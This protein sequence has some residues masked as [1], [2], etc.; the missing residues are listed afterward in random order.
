MADK[1]LV[2]DDSLTV[3]MDLADALEGAG[4]SV[5]H[6]ASAEEARKAVERE[7]VSVIV[8][9]VV[10]PDAD[11]IELLGELKQLARGAPAVLLLSSE[12]E[13]R[14]RIRGMSVGADDYVGKPYDVNHV[15]AR[16]REFIT[17]RRESLPAEA[18]ILVIDDSRTF[19]EQLRSG[20]EA[21]GYAVAVAASG[22][23]GLRV[24]AALRPQAILVDSE[25]PGIDGCNVI[26][27]VRLDAVL[28]STPC[29]LLT[30]RE[31]DRA[32]LDAFD[33][34]ADAFFRKDDLEIILARL[35]AVL[36]GRTTP[37]NDAVGLSSSKRILA[38]DDSP[39]YLASIVE[40]LQRDGYDVV[41]ATS[42]EEGIAM[43][44]AQAIDCI[45]L[46]LQ[47]P[48]LSGIETC[49]RVKA[50]P[51]IREIPLIVLTGREDRE[52]MIEA[53]GSG[54]D[55]FI[56]KSSDIEVVKARVRA[57]LRRKQFEDEHR[58]IHE[59]LMR[60]EVAASEARA[61]REL[62][63]TRARLVEELE[64]KNTELREA[65]AELQS[66]QQNLIQSGKM[67]SLGE[68]VAGVA[69]ELNNPLAF[70]RSHLDTVRRSLERVDPVVQSHA[71][72]DAL[73]AWQK[74]EVRLVEVQRG[75]ERMTD[76][77]VKL[78]TFSRLDEGE[79]KRVDL[80][81]SID[82]VLTIL[83][84]RCKDRI[85]ITI[86]VEEPRFLE[87]YAS[88]LNQALM[89][90]VSN[91][92]D[93][94][95]ETG[96]I[97]ISSRHDGEHVVIEVTDS[98]VGIPEHLRQRVLEPFFTTKPVGQGTGLGLSITY[99]IVRKHGGTIELASSSE[100][101][102]AARIRIPLRPPSVSTSAGGG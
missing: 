68:L 28:R 86:D 91:A 64:Q 55:D 102:T 1:I 41:S 24:A 29:V 50:A 36:R 26:R 92:I 18:P 100:G 14:D 30:A 43:L 87:C 48:G 79:L 57:Q 23:E 77:V 5:I 27:H 63:R 8:L 9:D 44:T 93:A 12:A 16:C 20:L 53:L 78:R 70:V 65:Y 40:E 59:R 45:L 62:L 52:A 33:A 56:S 61:E 49:Q 32:E 3:R 10:L 54:A 47:M 72:A 71:E 81:E 75:L 101:G 39:T 58:L 4:I 84:H 69:H 2:V 88:L 34:G 11:G 51:G 94:I 42:G 35:G 31:G 80:G 99:S 90:L 13:V 96:T 98:G 46:D 97:H 67:A 25:M 38:V 21:S 83:R 37:S 19:R 66:T 7:Q 82:A 73:S 95:E 22:E 89:N 17:L 6:A 76:L 60:S 74:A 15:L 85:A